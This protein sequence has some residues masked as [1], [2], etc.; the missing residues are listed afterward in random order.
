VLVGFIEIAG[1]VAIMGAGAAVQG[2]AGFGS[3][4]VAAPLLVLI[5][6]RLVPGPIMLAA[7]VLDFL[8]FKRDR[9]SL[10]LGGVK[11]IVLGMVPGSLLGAWVVVRLD[12]EALEVAVGLAVYLAVGL[13]LLGL[14]VRQNQPNLSGAGFLSGLLGTAT[15]LSGPPLALIY[16]HTTGSRL[17]ATLAGVFIAGAVLSLASLTLVGRMGQTEVGLGLVMVPGV[18]V[19]FTVSSR[20][21]PKLDRGFTRPAVLAISAAAASVLLLK[22]LF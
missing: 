22:N 16:Q 4:L 6:P 1:V 19:G 12:K 5:D 21:A 18:L 7:L 11:W 9:A 3:A 10:D 2:S 8:V 14:K 15:S 20:I 17:R 13:S